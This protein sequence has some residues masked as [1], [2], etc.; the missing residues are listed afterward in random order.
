MIASTHNG[1]TAAVDKVYLDGIE[2]KSVTYADTDN[3]FIV[4]A[5]KDAKD[6]FIVHNDHIV[7][8]AVTGKVEIT[9]KLGWAYCRHSESFKLYKRF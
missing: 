6:Q 7:S 2:A 3:G 4:R 8:E 5:K 1:G 9:L